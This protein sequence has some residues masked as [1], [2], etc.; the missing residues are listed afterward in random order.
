[1]KMKT[2]KYVVTKDYGTCRYISSN[3]RKHTTTVMFSSGVEIEIPSEEI[4][5]YWS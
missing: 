4:V 1:M 3:L 5:E 2:I